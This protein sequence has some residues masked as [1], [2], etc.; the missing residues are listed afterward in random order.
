MSTAVGTAG[1]L[2]YSLTTNWATRSCREGWEGRGSFEPARPGWRLRLHAPRPPPPDAGQA[3]GPRGSASRL[4]SARR[5]PAS[6]A[7]L[8]ACSPAV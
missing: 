7:F 8:A 1:A 5:A 6:S 4:T 3:A 2:P